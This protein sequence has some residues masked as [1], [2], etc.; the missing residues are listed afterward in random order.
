MRLFAELKRRNV[1]KVGIAY[2]V[3]V[4]LLIQIASLVFLQLGL[5][6]WAPTLVTVLLTLGFPVAMILAWAFELTPEDIKQSS[7]VGTEE[8]TSVR[9][10]SGSAGSVLSANTFCPSL[11]P[12]A[13]R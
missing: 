11:G 9:A 4:W 3:V 5:P 12:V 7:L 10:R 2:L 8:A 6:D 1:F 13:I